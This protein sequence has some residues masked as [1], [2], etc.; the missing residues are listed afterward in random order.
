ELTTMSAEGASRLSITPIGDGPPYTDFAFRIASASPTIGFR[1]RGTEVRLRPTRPIPRSAIASEVFAAAGLVDPDV[2]LIDVDDLLVTTARSGWGR[3]ART[4]IGGRTESAHAGARSGL[5]PAGPGEL[6]LF[7][8]RGDGAPP[9]M[10]IAQ[11]GLFV[12]MRQEPFA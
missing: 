2:L 3:V 9:W 7:V 4:P 1:P 12:G 8:G 10:T 5:K 6:E 11:A